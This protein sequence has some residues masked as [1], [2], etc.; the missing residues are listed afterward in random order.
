MHVYNILTVIIVLTAVFGYINFRFIKLPGI[1]GIMMISLIA[2]LL[3]IIIGKI[4]PTFYQSATQLISGIDFHTAL[5]K[6]MLSFL[7]FAGA[8]N[9]D[10]G[11]LKKEL[12][13][14]IVFST[15]GIIISTLSVATMLFSI[16]ELFGYHIDFIYCLLFGALISPT[17]PIAALGILKAA[18]IPSSLEIKISGESLFNDGV[19]VVLFVTIL[20]VASAGMQNF[21]AGKALWLFARE[22]VGG[23]GFGAL[24]GYAGF[25]A[26]RSIDNYKVETLIT[27]AI[28][29]GGF[30][31]AS[32]IHVSGPL[33]IVVAGIITGNK[34]RR[35]GMSDI[36]RNYIDNFWEM[37][38]EIMNAI[39]FLLIGFEMLVLPFNS[40]LLLLGS[41]TI[42][43]TLAA[44]Y[45]SVAIPVHVLQ[46]KMPFEK[47][48]IPILTWGGIRGGLSVAM[49]LSIP[50][51]MFG[52]TIVSITYIVVL[53]SI[54]VQGLT[55]GGLARKLAK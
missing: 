17:D 52:E 53:F 11:K 14:V 42:V 15:I 22:A 12:V 9:I 47:N 43:I 23:V 33:A 54:I 55:I 25:W 36:T 51:E 5:L 48:A 10:A 34:S 46:Y 45:L 30:L 2:S 29:M 50:R 16:A 6:I 38:D 3:I 24:L 39:L 35:E 37:I 4:N 44:R 19:G 26:L 40:T 1:I 13:P 27:I 21:S 31:L 41:I 18:K 20:E 8:I 49:A 28:V 32:K 7:L